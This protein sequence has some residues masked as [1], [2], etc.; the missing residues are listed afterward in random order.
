MP[1]GAVRGL[2]GVVHAF[3][4]APAQACDLRR[5][6]ERAVLAARE[7]ER[8]RRQKDR[9]RPVAGHGHRPRAARCGLLDRRRQARRAW[10]VEAVRAHERLEEL[11]A[12]RVVAARLAQ[13]RGELR[14]MLVEA[15]GEVQQAPVV[16]GEMREVQR[17][18]AAC[19]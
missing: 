11:P 2:A 1:L 12:P 16:R 3:D 17:S 13:R 7:R 10:L 9:K 4:R 6:V 19:R 8:D 14:G 18:A 5:D 15:L